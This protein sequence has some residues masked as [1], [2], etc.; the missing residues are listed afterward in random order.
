VRV[1]QLLRI[2]IDGGKGIAT[3]VDQEQQRLLQA[4]ANALVP[5]GMLLQCEEQRN[6]RFTFIGAAIEL[7][8]LQRRLGALAQVDHAGIGDFDGRGAPWRHGRH[9]LVLADGDH[10]RTRRCLA[11]AGLLASA[12]DNASQHG[13]AEARVPGRSPDGSPT[14]IQATQLPGMR[15]DTAS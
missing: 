1:A 8:R 12:S 13:E 15:C 14:R 6:R 11:L 5:R 2:G 10:R 7:R 4:A 3:L 9:Q